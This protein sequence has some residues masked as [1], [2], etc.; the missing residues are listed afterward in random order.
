MFSTIVI[1]CTLCGF[2]SSSGLHPIAPAGSAPIVTA[3]SSQ[4]FERTFNRLVAADPVLQPVI[5]VAPVPVQPP[6]AVAPVR[7][8]IPVF[9][10][11]SVQ[12]EVV[13]AIRTT[14]VPIRPTNPPQPQDNSEE[15]NV[16]IAIATAH[17]AAPVA[18]ILLP[19]YPFGFPPSF[20]FVPQTSPVPTEVPQTKETT[21][22]QSTTI[23]PQATT[24]TERQQDSITSAPTNID[25][26]FAQALPSNENVNFRQYL[27]PQPIPLPHPQKIKTSVEVVPVPLQ[28]IAP[29]PL[30][31]HHHHHHHH[32]QHHHHHHQAI[33]VV[34]HFHTFIPKPHKIIIR[35]ISGP[36]RIRMMRI[37]AGL[38]TYGPPKLVRGISK[39]YSQSTKP[40][41]RNTEVSKPLPLNRPITQPPRE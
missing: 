3:S 10:V 4:Y 9:P 37:P 32:Q 16:A 29:P 13:D 18:T 7:P 8:I 23:Q 6:V 38:A 21:T 35:P 41:P 27:A 40:K 19:P 24:T 26:S 28:Y 39:K 22:K 12:P 31:L 34:P 2:S 15:P 17:A 5:P 25:N 20:G 30:N 11:P 36:I 14:S 1:F 33:K